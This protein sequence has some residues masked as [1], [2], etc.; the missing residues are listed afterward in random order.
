[1]TEAETGWPIVEGALLGAALEAF[2]VDEDT[3]VERLVRFREENARTLQRFRGAMSDLGQSL[4]QSAIRPEAT[5]AAARDVYRTR[6][7]PDLGTLEDRLKESRIKFLTRSIFGAAALAITPLSVPTALEGGARL[8][9]QSIN[10]RFSR[11]RLLEEHPYG[12]LHRLSSADFIVP[13]EYSAPELVSST[14]NPARAV[15]EYFETTYEVAHE[16]E[17]SRG[18]SSNE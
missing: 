9:A 13:R 1:M 5:L 17:R 18:E 8:G 14:R 4:R 7:E 15:H 11:D 16:L 10:Y 3:P 2:V 12:Y 6:V